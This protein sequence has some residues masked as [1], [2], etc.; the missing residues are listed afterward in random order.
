M[1][2]NTTNL[3][4]PV[5]ENIKIISGKKFLWDGEEY[6][7]ESAAQEN[8]ENYSKDGFETQL[9]KENGIAR[10]FTRRVAKEVIVNGD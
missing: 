8:L 5:M 7:S 1:N 6:D 9:T 4:R 2:P 3:R 10:I